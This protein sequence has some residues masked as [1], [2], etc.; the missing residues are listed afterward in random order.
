LPGGATTRAAA[1]AGSERASV[2]SRADVKALHILKRVNTP[3][4][5]EELRPRAGQNSTP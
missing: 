4:L 5:E 2:S 1:A 3:N